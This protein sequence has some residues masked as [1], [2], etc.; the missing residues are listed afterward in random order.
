MSCREV[1]SRL[2]ADPRSIESGAILELMNFLL[3][4]DYLRAQSLGAQLAGAIDEPSLMTS[5]KT[6][7]ALFVT[8]SDA[9]RGFLPAIHLLLYPTLWDSLPLLDTPPAPPAA[10]VAHAVAN[11]EAVVQQLS[12]MQYCFL[13]L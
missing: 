4:H 7:I 9:W 1:V 11:K 10:F 12:V 6:Q 13:F 8:K 5:T 2:T 3:A